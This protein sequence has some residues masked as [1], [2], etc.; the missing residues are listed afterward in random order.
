MVLK[1]IADKHTWFGVISFSI[2]IFINLVFIISYK[3]RTEEGTGEADAEG[4]A[5]VAEEDKAITK[6]ARTAV[7]VLSLA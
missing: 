5:I 2:V 4:E 1:K 3:T 6:A 7:E